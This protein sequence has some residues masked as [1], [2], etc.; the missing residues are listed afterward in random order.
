MPAVKL[1]W[2][3]HVPSAKWAGA[4]LPACDRRGVGGADF[5]FD[6]GLPGLMNSFPWITALTS[7]PLAGSLVL[8]FLKPPH[9][10]LARGVALG[11]SLSGLVLAVCLWVKFD[12]TSGELQFVERHVW[13]RNL[14]VEY[15]VGV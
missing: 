11:F 14:A 2:Q 15:F 8:L 7:V 3:T 1:D 13:I 12:A 10:R 5:G 4:K 6:L 9:Q